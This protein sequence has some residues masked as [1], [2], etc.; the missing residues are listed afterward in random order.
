M[1]RP[2]W[3]STEED[4][5]LWGKGLAY[6]NAPIQSKVALESFLRAKGA[7]EQRINVGPQQ[8]WNAAAI[9][10]AQHAMG[11]PPVRATPAELAREGSRALGS[12]PVHAINI[13][14]AN[15]SEEEKREK[16]KGV[17]PMI[18]CI[19]VILFG[20]IVG[21]NIWFI[22]MGSDELQHQNPQCQDIAQWFFIFGVVTLSVLVIRM[23]HACFQGPNQAKQDDCAGLQC[24]QIMF[25]FGWFVYGCTLVADGPTVAVGCEDTLYWPMYYIFVALIP[26]VFGLLCCVSC[27]MACAIIGNEQQRVHQ[28]GVRAEPLATVMLTTPSSSRRKADSDPITGHPT[29]HRLSKRSSDMCFKSSAQ[30]PTQ[31]YELQAIGRDPDIPLN[32]FEYSTIAT[33]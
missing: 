16:L 13:Y 27:C 19:S 20:C 25:D 5:V 23:L 6:E 15:M 26:A 18:L 12:N 7:Q 31:L 8:A 17:L 24:L 33:I 3:V 29:V 32:C 9:D 28:A 10:Q 14:H 30:V 22:V 4:E 21:M 2:S 11:K 1:S